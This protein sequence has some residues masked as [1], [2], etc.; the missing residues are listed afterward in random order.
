MGLGKPPIAMQSQYAGWLLDELN[1]E[2]ETTKK[3]LERFSFDTFEYKPHPKSM[4][5]GYLVM[6]VAG[7]PGWLKGIAVDGVIDIGQGGEA[8]GGPD[9]KS[10]EDLLKFY[11]AN[12]KAAR[13]ALSNLSDDDLEKDFTLKRE[14]QELYTVKRKIDL[15][16]SLNHWVHHRGQLTVYM[17]LNDIEVPA[18]YGPSADDRAF[19]TPK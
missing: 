2:Y 7:I 9:I 19:T 8:G 1:A 5:M 13:E 15:R 18:L 3:C 12:V 14:G 11:D 6:L 10:T 4:N 16:V 17:R